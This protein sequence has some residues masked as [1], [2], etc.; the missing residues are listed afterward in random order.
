MKF[1]WVVAGTPDPE[2][3]RACIDLE[4]R[5]RPK[6]TKFLL[7]KLDSESCGDFSCFHF[8]VDFQ[9]QWVWISTKTPEQYI[10]LLKADFDREINGSPLFSVA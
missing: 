6:I 7:S 3:K 5:L 9:K 1:N 8:D 4:Y 2:I 10:E